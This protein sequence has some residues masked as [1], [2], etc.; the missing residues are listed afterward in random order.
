MR[1][2][3]IFVLVW[4]FPAGAGNDLKKWK[5][6]TSKEGGFSITFPGTPETKSTFTFFR[7]GDGKPFWMMA[8]WQAQKIKLDDKK[9]ASDFLQGGQ[10]GILAKAKGMLLKEV[11]FERAGRPARDFSFRS[12]KYGFVRTRLILAGDKL[13]ILSFYGE[14]EKLLTSKFAEHY[15]GSF[16]TK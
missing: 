5:K 16:T 15:F 2:P 8:I 4:V 1:I 14:T 9:V 11:V 3:I 13:Y 12:D 10:A 6:F 7:E